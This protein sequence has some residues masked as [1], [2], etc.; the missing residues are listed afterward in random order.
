MG[1]K[2]NETSCRYTGERGV[3]PEYSPVV[4]LPLVPSSIYLA[5]PEEEEVVAATVSA[6]SGTTD[7]TALQQQQ[8]A[9][10][11][12]YFTQQ[13]QQKSRNFTRPKNIVH[14][15]FSNALALVETPLSAVNATNAA[16]DDDNITLETLASA[17][18]DMI[19]SSLVADQDGGHTGHL[20]FAA[21][22]GLYSLVDGL[23]AGLT[24]RTAL[25]NGYLKVTLTGLNFGTSRESVT[26][27]KVGQTE[28]DSVVW[29]NS[30]TLT[31]VLT[32]GAKGG[33]TTASSFTEADVSLTIANA[34]TANG[35]YLEPMTIFKSGSGRPAI[36][37][38]TFTERPFRPLALSYMSRP[39]PVS[40][41][42]VQSATYSTTSTKKSSCEAFTGYNTDGNRQNYTV[43]EIEACGGDTVVASLCASDTGAS[44]KGD[45]LLSLHDTYYPIC[46]GIHNCEA[47]TYNSSL[48]VEND[49]HCGLCSQVT[50]SVPV[51]GNNPVCSTYYLR[52]GCNTNEECNGTTI[53]SVTHTEWTKVAPLTVDDHENGTRRIL[54]WS[55]AAPGGYGLFRCWLHTTVD[56]TT[57]WC[58]QTEL[59]A[60]NVQ[61][62]RGL[63]AVPVGC[64]VG[65]DGSIEVEIEGTTTNQCDLVLYA[66]ATTG[67]LYRLLL[68]ALVP[69]TVYDADGNAAMYPATGDGIGS[70]VQ[71]VSGI[72]GPVGLA[73]DI[74]YMSSNVNK[75][76]DARLFVTLLEGK[77]LRFDMK[78]I[79]GA[80]SNFPIVLDA[81]TFGYTE[82][83]ALGIV[84]VL[85]S[86]SKA[87][88]G[89]LSVVPPLSISDGETTVVSWRQ[90]RVF[91]V[92]SNQNYLYAA[93]EWRSGARPDITLDVNT[94][95]DTPSAILMPVSIA[96]RT[97]SATATSVDLYIAEYL[98]KIWKVTV[99]LDDTS[100]EVK[101]TEFAQTA[102][103]IVLDE[104][105][106]TSSVRIRAE[107]EV[108][109]ASGVPIYE[110][111]FFEAL[112]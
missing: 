21:A 38:V 75:A 101:S 61:R 6:S 43:C 7:L 102:P 42:T 23:H 78:V 37:T 16:T 3:T 82:Y 100:G 34:G 108:A 22:H 48:L 24:N 13:Q 45:T 90:H 103:E 104:S 60:T 96:A 112:Q 31:C 58:S 70:A 36:S 68:P 12:L 27:L 53:V 63:Q 52:Q 81:A 93:T 28:C 91:V 49:N 65:S 98:G 85:D 88:F 89:G 97:S 57:N 99:L 107:A 19:I 10:A 55:D 64:N 30:T 77:L 39:V 83:N 5:S 79:L 33:L 74:D 4:D 95:Y 105:R 94:G 50:Y 84:T 56:N 2:Y 32:G 71:L 25:V 29:F 72:R 11:S 62:A 106:F 73:V 26:S 9:L 8:A 110:R 35:V 109:K 87:R 15:P 67:S 92:D 86:P 14:L 69:D 41:A 111:V 18:T 20:Y 44:C 1:C 76:A 47:Y 46:D 66:D 17:D 54:Y 40:A 80:T 51:V 59:V